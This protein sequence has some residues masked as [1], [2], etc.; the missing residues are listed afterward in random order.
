[1]LKALEGPYVLLQFDDW[2]GLYKNGKMIHQGHEIPDHVWLAELGGT[3]SW[4]GFEL[5]LYGE[6]LATFG[7][8]FPYSLDEVRVLHEDYEQAAATAEAN[9][10]FKEWL[11]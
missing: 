2:C 9:E 3:E 7:G 8:Q 6:N 10:K 5:D 11:A 4:D 1:M